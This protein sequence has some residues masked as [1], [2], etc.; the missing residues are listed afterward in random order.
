MKTVL[1][2]GASDG[3]GAASARQLSADGHRVLIAGRSQEKTRAVARETGA[4]AFVAD[5]SRLDDVRRLAD[6]VRDELDGSGLDVLANNAGGLFGDRSRTIDGNEK[7]FQVNHLAPFLLTH[8][9]LDELH[10]IAADRASI[11]NTS[12]VGNRL[13]GNID[14]NDLHND[15]KF[16]PNKAYGDAK[17]ANILFTRGLHARL[18]DTGISAV[19]F[20]PGNVA[21]NFASDT[22]SAMRFVYRTPLRR[23]LISS[24]KGGDNLTWFVE[25]EPDVAWRSG[26]YYDEKKHS[27]KVNP[28]V[29]DDSLVEGLWQRSAALVGIG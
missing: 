16:S 10:A 21:T 5:F 24:E 14:L 1:I 18:H 28:Q 7:T 9:L 13:F 19:A 8:L 6:E 2:T 29:H 3:I 22:S 17:L 20:H 15:K 27:T 25:G 23:L 12:S 26:E 4:T 11:I